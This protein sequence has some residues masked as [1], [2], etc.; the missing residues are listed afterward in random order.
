MGGWIMRKLLFIIF[1]IFLSISYSNIVDDTVIVEVDTNMTTDTLFDKV[2]ETI[3]MSIVVEGLVVDVESGEVPQPLESVLIEVEGDSSKINGDGEFSITIP[4]KD[5]ITIIVTAPGYKTF[6]QIINTNKTQ[7]NYFISCPVEKGRDKEI[8]SITSPV[9]TNLKRE[10]VEGPPWTIKGIITDSR[11]DIPVDISLDSIVLLFNEDT[12]KVDNESRKRYKVTTNEMGI[13]AFHLYIPGYHEIHEQITLTMK[14]KEIFHVISTTKKEYKHSRREITVSANRQPLHRKAEPS[15]TVISREELM[16]TSAT[17]NDPIRVLQTLP[18]VASESDASARPIVRGGDV[19]EARVFLDGI[20]LIQP[21]H[22]G[23]ARSIFNQASV[24]DLAIYKTGFPAQFHNAQSAIITV[25]SRDAIEDSTN[26]FFD[27]N[28]LQYELY[29][30]APFKNRKVGFYLCSQ[31]SYSNAIF[32]LASQINERVR[33]NLKGF[34]LPDYQ[35][36]GGGLIFKPN[37]KLTIKINESF[38]TDRLDFVYQDE[39]QPVRYYYDAYYYIDPNYGDISFYEGPT[40]NPNIDNNLQD[41][42]FT[43]VKNFTYYDYDD[44]YE[45]EN[46]PPLYDIDY[47]SLKTLSRKM[48]YDTLLAYRSRYN[49]LHGTATYIPN[50]ENTISIRAAWQ[51]RWWDL[52][53]PE[54]YSDY[55]SK[56]IYDVVINQFNIYG[57]WFSTGNDKHNFSLG[58]QLDANLT[59]YNV[60]NL[61]FIHELITKGNTNFGEYLGPLSHDTAF[62]FIDA[63]DSSDYWYDEVAD[64]LLIHYKGSKNYLTGGIYANDEF[65]IN[66]RFKVNAGIRVE[67]STV[68]E[69]VSVSPR[70]STYFSINPKN[71]WISSV[72][73][74]TQNNYDIAAIAL[75]KNLQPE[76]VWHGG[77]GL[78]TEL[79]PWLNQEVD[80]YG[81][82]YYD[83]ISERIEPKKSQS[84]EDLFDSLYTFF[85]DEYSDSADFD[86]EEFLQNY[87]IKYG[88]FLYESHYTNNGLGYA[89]G[90]E[91]LLRYNPTDF[92]HGWISFSLGHSMR[93]RH[94]GWRWHNFPLERPV[95]FSLVN[96]YRLPRNYEVALKFRYMSGIPY[97]EFDFGRYIGN[98]NAK[99]YDSYKRLDLR[100]TKKII[101]K[102]STGHFYIELWNILNAPNLFLLDSDDKEVESTTFNLPTTAVFIGFDFKF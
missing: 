21:Y 40:G 82:Y 73:H 100:F 65:T 83:L 98:Y 84:Y 26:L 41:T 58:I 61:R 91:Y 80:I 37:S 78:K 35:D 79:L 36:F 42:S 33:E 66:D 44:T 53:F 96:Y 77:T 89:Y 7:E 50:S 2:N 25:Q 102:R 95:L 59:N 5:H 86:F 64:R 13:H 31:G 69:K 72:G 55:I 75:S 18:S 22:F 71:E 12:V 85:M 97:T 39:V 56:S 87:Q 6:S 1:F 52:T 20:S 15:K 74:Y 17:M 47:D 101:G 81:K 76:K 19:L 90:F 43:M 46:Y 30:G 11:L 10:Y 14:Q 62:S 27:I 88:T 4:Y 3:E 51:R 24:T 32:K 54:E 94:K 38:N 8:V 67:G 49:I 70:V 9:G 48:E 60:H 34:N 68:D 93:Q 23:G 45:Y 63:S 92:W 99:R 57:D 28:L 16:R 29:I